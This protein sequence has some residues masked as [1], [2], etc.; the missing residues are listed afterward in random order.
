MDEQ[1]NNQTLFQDAPYAKEIN[2]LYDAQ[3]AS[4]LQE[5]ESAYNQNLQSLQSAQSQIAPTYATQ[6]NDLAAQY[7]RTRMNN[8]LQAA[9]RG[10][11][12]GAG[13]QMALAQQGNYLSAYGNLKAQQ[14]QAEQAMQQKL[15]ELELSYKNSVAQAIADNDYQRALA[16]FN[17]YKNGGYGSSGSSGSRGSGGGS[18]RGSG[19][20]TG[21]IQ[22]S[23]PF[24]LGDGQTPA[25]LS[26]SS[27]DSIY[28]D[29]T[30]LQ[31]LSYLDRYGDAADASSALMRDLERTS[32]GQ[33][34]IE[35]QQRGLRPGMAGYNSYVSER[36]KQLLEE[37]EAYKY[38]SGI[39][40]LSAEQ[41]KAKQMAEEKEAFKKKTTDPKYIEQQFMQQYGFTTPLQEIADSYQ[42]R[43]Y[44][45]TQSIKN[46]TTQKATQ[47]QNSK[48]KYQEQGKKKTQQTNKKT[49][50]AA[51]TQAAQKKKAQEAANKYQEQGKKRTTQVKNKTK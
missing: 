20:T 51:R 5:L 2:A 50:A 35:A 8:N 49:S 30:H 39:H 47:A 13:S 29:P 11:N 37:N 40:S 32:L 19:S 36:S 23:A 21:A 45:R 16:L 24:S 27:G 22:G 3:K 42:Q 28:D 33:A 48:N 7:E 43:G 46:K 34:Q 18:R 38:V 12:T 4:Q 14:A 31:Y 25:A 6:A 15:A 17:E 44:N 10:L 41:K 1:E 26:E 9:S